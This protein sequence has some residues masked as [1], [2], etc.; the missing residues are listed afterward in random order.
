MLVDLGQLAIPGGKPVVL[1]DQVFDLV[2]GLA[3]IECRAGLRK[4]EPA[5]ALT[6][7][8]RAATYMKRAFIAR[9]LT[10]RPATAMTKS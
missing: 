6:S 7:P 4:R 9:G 8:K 1:A 5:P 10:H 2:F 3:A